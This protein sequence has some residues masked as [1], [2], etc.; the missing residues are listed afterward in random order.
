MESWLAK[1]PVLVS[2]H[3]DV[4]THFC[5]ETN[6]GL[7]YEDFAT[8][9]ATA[10]YLLDHKDIADRMGENGFR[11]VRK[12]FTHEVIAKKYLQFIDECMK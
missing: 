3:C 2:R 5:L 9:A 7:Y 12:H 1:R 10:D 6:G 8:F 4:T 11:Y